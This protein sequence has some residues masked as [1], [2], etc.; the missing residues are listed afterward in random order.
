MLWAEGGTSSIGFWQ[1]PVL[2]E[3]PHRLEVE[4]CL[5]QLPISI[6]YRQWATGA[7]Q[8]TDDNRE[9]VLERILIGYFGPKRGRALTRE[10]L[11]HMGRLAPRG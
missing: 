11:A 10:T 2:I 6:V 8:V 3:E 9:Q 4:S 7:A 5:N 1:Y